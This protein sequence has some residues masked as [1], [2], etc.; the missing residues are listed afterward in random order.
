MMQ[1]LRIPDNLYD[2]VPDAPWI[3]GRKMTAAGAVPVVPTRLTWADTTGSWKAR[4]GFNRMNFRVVPGLYAIGDPN[5][6]SP[7]MVSANY[8]MSFDR[9]RQ[10]LA[11]VDAWILVLDT[12]G[13]NVWCAAG[14]GTFGTVEL[15]K[16]IART[17]LAQVVKHR[18]LILPQLGATGV[19]AHEVR[20]RSGFKVV[21]G[22]IQ[23]DD[24]PAFLQAGMKA[25]PEMRRVRFDLL[26]RLVLTPIELRGIITK[27]VVWLTALLLLAGRWSGLLPLTWQDIYP[28]LGALL[29]GA[30]AVPVLLPWIPGRAFALKGCWLGLLWV[31]ICIVT[32]G[33]WQLPGGLWLSL[34]QLLIIPSLS[35]YLAL[36]FTGASTYTSFSGVVKETRASM[37]FIK[38]GGVMGLLALVVALLS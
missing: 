23:S 11:G 37:P 24:I 20:K 4:W 16:R 22:P 31:I 36:Q 19:A 10:S 13:I 7:V 27:P 34:A 1:G 30:V 33:T 35:A 25:T 17:G 12:D 21:Y 15:V 32:T 2:T 5:D 3:N 28:Y 6:N 8:K 9:L 18:V 29:V 14:K 38:S 26:D